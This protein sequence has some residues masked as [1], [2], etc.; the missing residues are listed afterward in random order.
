MNHAIGYFNEAGDEYTLTKQ[1]TRANYRT[2]LQNN[3]GYKVGLDQFG[4]G[5]TLCRFKFTQQNMILEDGQRTIYFRDDATNDVWCVGGFPYV[6]QVEDY[7][8]THKQS[9][10]EISSVHNGIK[11]TIKVFVPVDKRCDIQSVR[12]ENLSGDV[13]SISIFPTV[14]L[15]LTG[16]SAPEWAHNFNQTYLTSLKE[17]INGLY[18][19]GRNPYAEGMPY[20]AYLTSTT[21]IHAYSADNREVFG[22][23][24]SL[25]EPYAIMEG[26]DLDSKSVAA[27]KLCALLQTKTTLNPGEVMETDYVLGIAKDFETAK[28][29]LADI[30]THE[31]VVRLYQKTEDADNLRRGKLV[32][33]TPHKETNYLM[34]HWLKMGLERNILKRS[35]P[36]DNLQFANAALIYIPDAA[37]YT[38]RNVMTQQH[39]DGSLVRNWMPLDETEY[40]DEPMWLVNLT[41]DYIK[42]TGDIAFL[43]EIVDYLDGGSDTVWVHLLKAIHRVDAD[44]GPHNIPL[45]H[46]ADW[47]DALNT[48]I[49]DKNAESVFV[50]M[51]LAFVFREMADLCEYLGKEELAEEYR[52]KYA[53][54]KQTINDNCW[55]EEGYYVRSFSHGKPIGSSKCEKGAKI[56]VNPQ[57]WSI[58]SEVCPAERLQSVLDAVDKYIDT[59][60]GCMVNYPAYCEADPALGRISFQYP[61]TS[62]NG[63]IYAHATSFKM[64][65]DCL[66][67]LGDRGYRSYLQLLPSNPD[68]PPE[69]S[70]TIPYAISNCCSTADVCY[71][72]S[73]ALPFGTGTQAWLFRTVTEGLLGVRFAYGGF[74]LRPAFP[75]DWDK[76]SMTLERRG[77]LYDITIVNNTGAKKIY[78]NGEPIDSDFVPFSTDKKVEIRVEL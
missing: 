78:V 35:N 6:S 12:I 3:R 26:E 5:E 25:S 8:C 50:A 61:G 14:K 7:K 53:E 22:T 77:T 72:K 49:S 32:I 47:N 11:V 69:I 29:E 44:R 30:R 9:C 58:I 37:K 55:D 24:Y 65:A 42:Y 38:I 75:S 70:D 34:N 18:V 31:D 27:G 17:E 16:F 64:Y 76:A 56:Y 33:Q 40:A 23:Q 45:S 46:F 62:E 13:R 68:N 39:Q 71:G 36:R 19:D 60:V 57:S 63:A 67:G 15:S 43:E 10:S 73:S 51:Q 48:G 28:T 66:L 52:E 2:C 59:P 74:T 41:C 4:M 21:P 20:N 54:L 1:R